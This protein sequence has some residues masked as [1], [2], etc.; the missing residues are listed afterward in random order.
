MK[1]GREHVCAARNEG[2][3][4][5][6]D[7]SIEEGHRVDIRGSDLSI[8]EALYTEETRSCSRL[9]SNCTTKLTSRASSDRATR[10][11]RVLEVYFIFFSFLF[12]F[13]SANS[14]PPPFAMSFFSLFVLVS[15]T[16][17]FGALSLSLSFLPSP[18]Y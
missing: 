17:L 8:A 9:A 7:G 13:F 1:E 18:L 15:L 5:E 4:R 14:P 2:K 11:I 6:I 16:S 3:D 12:F 10:A